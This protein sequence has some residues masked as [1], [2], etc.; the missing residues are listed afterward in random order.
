MFGIQY[1]LSEIEFPAFFKNNGPFKHS[2]H[3]IYELIIFDQPQL[4]RVRKMSSFEVCDE[5]Q[6]PKSQTSKKWFKLDKSSLKWRRVL[7]Y[8]LKMFLKKHSAGAEQGSIAWLLQR[9][10]AFGGSEIDG[11]VN[12][13]SPSAIK[14]FMA[15]K[16]YLVPFVGNTYTRWGNMMEE[17]TERFTEIVNRT[18]LKFTGSLPGTCPG[19]RYSP[20]G[21]AVVKLDFG[22]G[23]KWYIIL[24]EFKAPFCKIPYGK[25]PKIYV[26]QVK[27]GMCTLGFCTRA[28]FISNAYRVC[29]FKQLRDNIK[30]N[31]LIHNSD[32]RR[33][34]EERKKLQ[35]LRKILGLG[36]I[37][38]TINDLENLTKNIRK[39]MFEKEPVEYIPNSDEDLILDS[40]GD[41]DYN[42]KMTTA[43]MDELG[44]DSDVDVVIHSAAYKL[45]M[46][47]ENK[48]G[49][50]TYP[51]TSKSGKQN[52]PPRRK[53]TD[54]VGDSTTDPLSIFGVTNMSTVCQRLLEAKKSGKFV[55]I[56]KCTYKSFALFMQLVETHSVTLHYEE[57]LLFLDR[58]KKMP[59]FRDQSKLSPNCKDVS[60]K[61]RG[62]QIKNFIRAGRRRNKKS[63]AYM[64]WKLCFSDVIFMNRDKKY[65][66]VYEPRAA[67]LAPIIQKIL[68]FKIGADGVPYYDTRPSLNKIVEN[69][70]GIYPYQNDWTDRSIARRM[71]A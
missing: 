32:Y 67:A 42:V 41:E 55:D 57:P 53:H 31:Y 27:T 66:D 54:I 43:A 23:P 12:S 49:M 13:K 33:K 25:I 19:Q 17:V 71:D 18:K 4:S 40:S 35:S 20:D 10:L 22:D 6:N 38:F 7:V 5:V 21:L 62:K 58:I 8:R 69:F 61:E 59:F 56:G 29:S 44:S 28:I 36:L 47:S 60:D 45:R 14:S 46:L 64:P 68:E 34:G 30:Y 2:K 24:Y 15:G 3:L 50:G 9:L 1:F 48:S 26:P 51:R 39:P 37:S 70:Y 65:R 52:K 11:L 16:V 63:V